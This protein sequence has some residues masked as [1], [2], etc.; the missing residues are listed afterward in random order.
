MQDLAWLTARPIAHRGLHDAS[1]GIIE[2][3]RS[4]AIAAMEAG[5][6]IEAD[7]QRSADGEAMVFHDGAI[8]RLMEGTGA[9][10]ALPA[11]QLKAIPFRQTADRMLS[12]G[13]LCDLVAGRTPLLLELKSAFD[14][15]RR[16]ALRAADILQSY[17]G[18][19]AAMSFDPDLVSALRAAAPL[20]ARGILA[21]R[22]YDHPHWKDLPRDAVRRMTY[23]L[24][25]PQTRPQFIAYAVQD[26]PAFAPIAAKWILGL[27]LLTWTVRT[28][29]DRRRAAR[30]ADQIIFEGIRP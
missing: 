11:R 8:D 7:L 24:H 2:N 20:L 14:G 22:R 9:V 3:T 13:D 16:L 1:C 19:V 5:Y 4:A 29:D 6:G 10:A 21:S 28:D 18:P 26:L 15:D 23:F 12:L 27:P 17:R 25:F 30:W